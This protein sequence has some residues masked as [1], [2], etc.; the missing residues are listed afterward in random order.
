M[1]QSSFHQLL[2]LSTTSCNRLQSV[3]VV[4]PAVSLS[5]RPAYVLIEHYRLR[6]EH[7]PET[8]MTTTCLVPRPHYHALP[9]RFG[10]RGP[11]KFLSP[12]R[13]SRIRHRNALTERAWKDAVQG[14]GKT[15]TMRRKNRAGEGREG[16]DRGMRKKKITES[17]RAEREYTVRKESN[18]EIGKEPLWISWILR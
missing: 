12:G 4:S 7:Q 10:S 9:M 16:R 15:T 1:N 13:S 8:F 2:S 18:T 3:P 6:Q 17:R 5:K 14:L 11:R